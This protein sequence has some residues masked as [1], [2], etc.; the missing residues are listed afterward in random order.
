[1]GAPAHV[2]DIADAVLFFLSKRSKHIT[3][4][5]LVVDGGW[6]S[7]GIPPQ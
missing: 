5:N 6:T 4:Q 2:D 3:G 7:V 1:M